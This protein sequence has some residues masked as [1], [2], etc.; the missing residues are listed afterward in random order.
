MK[1]EVHEEGYQPPLYV[2]GLP[3]Y[4]DDASDDSHKAQVQQRLIRPCV[5]YMMNT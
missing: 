2:S 3:V 1:M 4:E 5:G